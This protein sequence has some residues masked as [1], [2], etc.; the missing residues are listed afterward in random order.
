MGARWS[1]NWQQGGPIGLASDTQV[2][3]RRRTDHSEFSLTEFFRTERIDNGSAKFIH[4]HEVQKWL[5]VRR[6]QDITG[7]WGNVSNLNRPPL[8]YEDTN[9]LR[10]LQDTVWY[11]PR[12]SRRR[13]LFLCPRSPSS[14]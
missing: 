14:V 5:D 13:S 11:L 12:R 2:Q 7:L 3:L 4:E 1:H 9:L 6:C 8:P 10:A